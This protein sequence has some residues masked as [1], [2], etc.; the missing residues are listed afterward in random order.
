[1]KSTAVPTKVVA[2]VVVEEELVDQ[3][4]ILI[5]I[6]HVVYKE[7]FTTDRKTARLVMFEKIDIYRNTIKITAS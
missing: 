5:L 6:Q 1:V 7:T 4:W 2:Q 3:A